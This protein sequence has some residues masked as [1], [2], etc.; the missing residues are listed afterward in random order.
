MTSLYILKNQKIIIILHILQRNIPF[1]MK[2]IWPYYCLK[3]FVSSPDVRYNNS[4][5]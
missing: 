3:S 4:C 5:E 2:H 1:I